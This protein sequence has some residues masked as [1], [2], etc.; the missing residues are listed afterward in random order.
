MA[1]RSQKFHG[2]VEGAADRCAVPGCA[3]A[4]EFKA[5]L[6]PSSFDGPGEWQW[7]CLDHVREHNARYNFFQGMSP[8]EIEAAQSPVAAW[9]RASRAFAHGGADPAPPWS[10]F[11]D[12]LD[13]IAGRFGA[14]FNAAAGPQS[15]FSAGE[16]RALEALGLG[17]DTDLHAVR[18]R[19]S[20]LVRRYHPD[21]NGGDRSQESKLRSVIDAWQTLKAAPAFA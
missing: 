17:P 20:E 12:P 4:G 18:K 19:Y 2:R 1:S 13:A 15:R 21:R 8:E 9:D 7:L 14:R 3:Q 5:P 11:R 6:S 10:D 16:R